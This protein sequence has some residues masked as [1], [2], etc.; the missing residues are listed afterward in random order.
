MKFEIKFFSPNTILCSSKQFAYFR[1]GPGKQKGWPPLFYKILYHP[2]TIQELSQNHENGYK[3]LYPYYQFSH[4]IQYSKV[5]IVH[6]TFSS[7]ILTYQSVVQCNLQL[8]KIYRHC[9]SINDRWDALHQLHKFLVY[10]RL[11]VLKI[12]VMELEALPANYFT[13]ITLSDILK[14]ATNVF[15][16]YF[17]V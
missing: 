8:L 7:S 12:L 3:S 11:L 5:S 1:C 10:M 13:E 2:F 14:F 17:M 15:F 6:L 4:E 9:L 16:Q